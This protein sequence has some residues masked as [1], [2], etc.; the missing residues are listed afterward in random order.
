MIIIIVIVVVV[1][2]GSICVNAIAPSLFDSLVKQLNGLGA[3]CRTRIYLSVRL[4]VCL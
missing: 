3:C 4:S 1:V 2:C